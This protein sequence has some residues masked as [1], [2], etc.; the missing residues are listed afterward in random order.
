MSKL[1]KLISQADSSKTRKYGVTGLGLII[2]KK[3]SELMGGTIPEQ[4]GP[5]AGTV[6]V[7][8]L[9]LRRAP[10]PVPAGTCQDNDLHSLYQPLRKQT[11][12]PALL[13]L[14]VKK[15][16][17]SER[18]NLLHG[19]HVLLAEV[20]PINQKIGKTMLNLP[21]CDVEVAVNGLDDALNIFKPGQ[22]DLIPMDIMMPEMDGFDCL[23]AIRAIHGME[24]LP[25][26]M[27]TGADDINS[28]KRSFQSGATDFIAKPI[29]W[30]ILPHRLRCLLRASPALNPLEKNA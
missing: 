22:T 3:S 11:L 30:P 13:N 4:S 29:N 18:Q 20:N 24:S 7:V 21:G 10:A 8:Q 15:Q 27:L 25:I 19:L 26:V 14:I 28:F 6:F 1:F 23:Q 16:S 5:G 9:P 17:S 2:C 12:Q